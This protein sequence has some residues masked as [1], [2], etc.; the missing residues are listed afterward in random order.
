[1]KPY[2]H[3]YKLLFR[4]IF[5]SLFLLGMTGILSPVFSQ[6]N[7]SGPNCVFGGGT[8]NYLISAYY[9]GSTTFHYSI[10]NG[11][12]STGGTSGN[13]T[14]PGVA[15]VSIIWNSGLTTGSI[16]LT[17]PNGF[18]QYNVTG[19]STPT[20]GSITSG[21]GQNLNYNAVPATITCGA[22]SGGGCGS[23]SFSYQWQQ[24]TNNSSFS[25]I[26]GAV[27]LSLTFNSGLTQ[28]MYYRLMV[29]EGQ[30]G[31]VVYSNTATVNVYAQLN[32][33]TISPLNI[34]VPPG[35][36][37]GQLT[38]SNP[39]GGNLSYGYVWWASPDNSTWQ[40]VGSSISYTPPI[41]YNT[42]YY[43]R[44]V[45]SNGVTLNT[46]TATVLVVAGVPP[47]DNS[48]G[49]ANVNMN[50]SM[51]ASYDNAGNIMTQDKKFFDNGGHTLQLQSKVFY[52]KNATT[53]YTHVLAVQPVKD[54]Y[55]RVALNTM[56]APTDYADFIYMPGFITASD[57]T[58]YSYKNFDR[59]NPSGTETDKTNNPD[60]IGGQSTKGTLGWYYGANNNW[61]PYLA[62]SNYPFMR[63]SV[64]RDGTN[65]TKKSAGMGETYVMGSGHEKSSYIAPVSGELANY[66]AARNQLFSSTAIGSLPANLQGNATMTVAK[67]ANGNEKVTIS[68][69]GG[70]VLMTA[71][72][73]TDLTANNSISIANIPASLTQ[74]LTCAT[75]T[76]VSLTSF[77]GGNNVNIYLTSTTGVITSVYSGAASAVPLNTNVGNGTVVIVSDAP[78]S[79]TYTSS[80]ISYSTGSLNDPGGS[81][82]SIGYFKILADNTPV[83]ITGS[84]TLY[85]MS[86]ETTT[87]L[88]SGN[89]NRGYYKIVSTTGI[90]N[91]TYNNGLTDISYFFYNQ[92]GQL[93]ASVTPNGVKLLLG[94]GYTAYSTITAVP[95]AT[96][97]TYDAQGRLVQ[98]VSPDG[99]TSNIA[100]RKDGKIRFS[101][102]AVQAAS[103]KFSYTNYDNFGR[104]IESGEYDGTGTSYATASTTS[105]ILESTDPLAGGLGSGNKNDV[106]QLVFDVP[107]ATHNQANYIQDPANLGGAL[108]TS[109]RYSTVVNGSQPSASNLVSQ[110]WFSYNEEGKVVWKIQY[111]ASLGSS[112]YKT[113]DY[114]YDALSRLV[115]RIFQLYAG[116]ETFVHYFQYDPANSQLW[117]VYTATS[118][119]GQGNATLQAT[120]VYYLHGG[121]KRVELASNLQGIDYAYTLQGALKSI[122]NSNAGADPGND[123]IASNG[124]Q[125]DAFGEVLDYYPAD[126]N[127]GRSSGIV[128]LNGVNT[129]SIVPTE[130]YAGN[131][132]AMSWY[133]LKPSG[134]GGSISPTTYVYNYDPKYQLIAGTWGTGLNFGTTPAG[135]TTTSFNKETITIPGS[136]TPGS[137]A[138]DANGNILNLQ[139]TNSAGGNGDV[140]AYNY[141]AGTNRLSTI[142]N[143]GSASE[144]YN[145][146][147]D[148]L[149]RETG[150]NSGVAATTKY[151]RYDAMGRVTMVAANSDFSHPLAAFVYDEQGHR[152]EKISYNNSYTP[153]LA[154]YYFGDVIYTQSIT[155]GTSYGPLTP[156]E[157]QVSGAAGRIG[158]YSKPAAA[159]TYELRD[160]LGNVRAVV[161]PTGAVQTATDYYP[162]GM[163]IAT[164]GSGYRYG[165]QGQYAE[166]DGETG[167]NNFELRMYSSRF[168]RWM[169]MDPK[170]Q[171]W[172]SYMAMGNNPVSSVDKDGGFWQEFK[173][174]VITGF[175]FWGSNDALATYKYEQKLWGADNVAYHWDGSRKNGHGDV[176]WLDHWTLE[177]WDPNGIAFY[178]EFSTPN[179]EAFKAIHDYTFAFYDG[180]KYLGTYDV[181]FN[182]KTK[183]SLGLAGGAYEKFIGGL[184]INVLSVTL[185][186]YDFL[187]N[188]VGGLTEGQW[189]FSH[190]A[191]IGGYGVSVGYEV[192]GSDENPLSIKGQASLLSVLG[193]EYDFTGDEATKFSVGYAHEGGAGLVHQASAGIEIS[194]SESAPDQKV[195]I[196]DLNKFLPPGYKMP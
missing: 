23:P 175:Q 100:Y 22:A 12:L 181:F 18:T 140:L 137:P 5:L 178:K 7:I 81:I 56:S 77:T 54:A 114:T 66:V 185:N 19:A 51:T 165:Y 162:Y 45:S 6:N 68:D 60:P 133:S 37:P 28:T 143:T 83:S 8:Y 107:D 154:T 75:G 174:W 155:G 16:I 94:T 171:D 173:N 26:S 65:T 72:P 2:F 115:K 195:N 84:Y 36:S 63:A 149:G 130:S 127:N 157:Y 117:K 42:M 167:W 96:N 85:D 91:V 4:G 145:F 123:G 40:Q 188:K 190:G 90:V 99:G 120:Y 41:L 55:G 64:Y 97:F 163:A 109:K 177:D 50:W 116:G 196:Q 168:G 169:T 112:G 108:S 113:V 76:G 39:S 10:S 35:T 21:G 53:V 147:Y 129:G 152:I 67:D 92:L 89:L 71:R 138:Y 136:G 61:E 183:L 122:N 102:N 34:T 86:T 15:S 88:N 70:K 161:T 38:G 14:G 164:Y 3:L 43:Y 73:G 156:W 119:V 187:E 101:Q 80:G 32:P 159:Y 193:A 151:T 160:H 153:I 57:G 27:G 170:G 141:V 135:F 105:T 44:A 20:A 78:F 192:T 110:T 52:R 17:S 82:Q 98:K 59:F 134:S 79:L 158:V 186:S 111:I 1:M 47:A 25:S 124:F 182:F 191:K 46:P 29:T 31:A 179:A 150:E 69:L 24:S 172:S 189:E 106:I 128:S 142:V 126:Y 131:I 166:A 49:N 144:T 176:I 48:T 58:N 74:Q 121:L 87:S 62:T 184:S 146:A 9:S 118:D 33:G 125:P 11:V 103:G 132:K 13:H 30:S 93:A 95:F 194:K 139:R 148:Q 104:T 180:N